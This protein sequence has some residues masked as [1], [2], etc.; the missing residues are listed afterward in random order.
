MNKR[1][2]VFQMVLIAFLLAT[3]TAMAGGKV[4]PSDAMN[5]VTA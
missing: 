4:K 5:R 1:F 2:S 3:E